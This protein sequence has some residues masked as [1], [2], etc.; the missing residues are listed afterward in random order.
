MEKSGKTRSCHCTCIAGMGQSCNH[1]A[2]AIYKIK[3]AVRNVLTN[4]SCTNTSIWFGKYI[5]SN[6]KGNRLITASQKDLENVYL[7][8]RHFICLL[9]PLNKW[10]LVLIYKKQ[11]M[12]VIY[13]LYT[14]II[15]LESIFQYF[16]TFE[17]INCTFNIW[18]L[19]T[20]LFLQPMW[21]S[22]DFSFEQ[23]V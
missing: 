7:L 9:L 20:S 23:L 21:R 13:H 10:L 17:T 19:V 14:A 8:I 5:W 22:S 15:K 4:P 3:A 16:K 18:G 11:H 2:A 12:S 1:V 6:L